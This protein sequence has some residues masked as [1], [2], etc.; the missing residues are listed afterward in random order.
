MLPPQVKNLLDEIE[1]YGQENDAR[2]T[3]HRLKMLNLETVTARLV[4]FI[5]RSSRRRRILE[6]GTSNGYSTIW[7]AA[8]VDA[9]DGHVVSVD[10]NPAKHSLATANLQKAGLARRVKLVTGEADAEI[11]R[12][13]GPFDAL[14]FD[15]NRLTAGNQLR[16]LLPK[17]TPDAIVLADNVLSHPQEIAAYLEVVRALPDFAEFT[18]PIGKGLSIAYRQETQ[19]V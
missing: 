17:L 13:D 8:A 5:M 18:V 12:L 15:G 19:S 2:Q 16:A 6:I 3:D 9:L 10:R 14:F 7:L 4:H 1:T 11:T